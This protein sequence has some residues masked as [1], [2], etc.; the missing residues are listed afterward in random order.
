MN[1]CIPA[2]A[3][4]RSRGVADAETI[5]PQ[6]QTTPRGVWCWIDVAF[7]GGTAWQQRRVVEVIEGPNG[8]NR[9]CG[10]QFRF[11]NSI[12]APVRVAFA[13][14]SSWSH[15]GS[16]AL[17][18]DPESPTLNLG[19]VSA[20]ATPAEVQRVILHEFGH[21]LGLAHEHQHPGVAIPWDLERVYRYF[22]ATQGW[23]ETD[24]DSQVLRPLLA[25][26][27]ILGAYDPLSIMGYAI[28]PEL[29]TDAAWSRTLT[30]EISAE[31]R[32]LVQRLYGPPPAQG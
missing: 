24:V 31:D 3:W 11:N 19:W 27:S 12:T 7:L 6:D 32:A 20:W 22:R 23:S 9:A 1:L 10:V 29:L 26:V 2:P 4:T 13:E 15:L 21:A 28:P 5:W 8:W 30:T 14:G 18:A 25:E 17:T 16:R